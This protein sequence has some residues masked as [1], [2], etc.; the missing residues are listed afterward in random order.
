MTL[1]NKAHS[2]ISGTAQFSVSHK[3]FTINLYDFHVPMPG[4]QISVMCEDF[5]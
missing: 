5:R 1:F 3:H 4:S 2:H